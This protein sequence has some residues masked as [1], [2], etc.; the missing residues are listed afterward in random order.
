MAR[1]VHIF[2]PVFG[3]I[4]RLAVQTIGFVAASIIV[5]FVSHAQDG[6]QTIKNGDYNNQQDKVNEIDSVLL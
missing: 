2:W 3:R 1:R 4:K 6:S 5:F